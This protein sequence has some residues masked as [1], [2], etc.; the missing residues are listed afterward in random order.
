MRRLKKTVPSER[1]EILSYI[2]LAPF[3][4]VSE[5][6]LALGRCSDHYRFRKWRPGASFF[7][8]SPGV[9]R[10]MYR[11]VRFYITSLLQ[12]PSFGVVATLVGN[13]LSRL[14]LSRSVRSCSGYLRKITPPSSIGRSEPER[15]CLATR[16]PLLRPQA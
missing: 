3:L 6:G 13:S 1:C 8:T 16:K 10:A 2:P 4:G 7:L 11:R 5:R 15:R 9:C 12:L 14:S